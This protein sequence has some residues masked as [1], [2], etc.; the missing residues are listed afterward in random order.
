MAILSL[1]SVLAGPRIQRLVFSFLSVIAWG[2][3]ASDSLL[4]LKNITDG[5][6]LLLLIS[7]KPLFFVL[8]LSLLLLVL[9]DIC[10][11]ALSKRLRIQLME[12]TRLIMVLID[13]IYSLFLIST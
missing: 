9:E 1:D 6:I 4:L 7:L 3:N 12:C 8:V 10:D 2:N 13:G 5:L 11:S